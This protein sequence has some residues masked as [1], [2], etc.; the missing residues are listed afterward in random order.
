MWGNDTDTIGG[1]DNNDMEWLVYRGRSVMTSLQ[2]LS[3]D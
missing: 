1:N 2:G 3:V